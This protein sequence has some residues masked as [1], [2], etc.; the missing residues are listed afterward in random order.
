MRIQSFAGLS[1]EWIWTTALTIRWRELSCPRNQRDKSGKEAG[2]DPK[3]RAS[4]SQASSAPES[5]GDL[6]KIQVPIQ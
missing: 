6:V 2:P 3:H 5:P 1:L 4:E